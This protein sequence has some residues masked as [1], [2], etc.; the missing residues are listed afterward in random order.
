M[1]PLSP[2]LGRLARQERHYFAADGG[3][4]AVLLAA[5]SGMDARLRPTHSPRHADTLIVATPV[6]ERFL[7][8]L[9]ECYRSMPEPRSLVLV[10]GIVDG[11]ATAPVESHA[12]PAR[13]RHTAKSDATAASDAAMLLAHLGGAGRVADLA[14]DAELGARAVAVAGVALGSPLVHGAAPNVAPPAEVLVPV[15]F[16]GER[17]LATENAVVPIGP[18]QTAITAGPLALLL[19]T[20]GEQ[21]ARAD[22]DAGY[23]CRGLAE[24]FASTPWAECLAI[25]GAL[26]PLAPIAGRVAWARAV[27][28]L[29][30]TTTSAEEER[31]REHALS[32]ERAAGALAWLVRFADV[33]AYGWLAAAARRLLLETSALVPPPH[34]VV[35]GDGN[36]PRCA[37]GSVTDAERPASL[38]RAMSRLARRIERDRLLALRTRGLGVLPAA[39]VREAGVVGANLAASERGAGDV[40]ARLHER[41]HAAARDLDRANALAAADDAAIAT[42]GIAGAAPPAAPDAPHPSGVATG[43]AE[44][45]RGPLRITVES[46]GGAQPARVEWT[47]PSAAALALLPELLRGQ[48]LADALAIVASLDLSMAEADG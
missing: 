3:S 8:P 11:T 33:V 16:P 25:A 30:G 9:A 21:V 13:I 24:R 36:R 15:G 14:G 5:L 32:L 40:A 26:D 34:M 6:S 1:T 41:A 10:C 37:R 39:R 42:S 28:R 46:D 17:E 47:R 19:V 48:E 31:A 45:P 29:D 35:P 20:D 23:A 7:A 38:A 12:S 44:G 18:V 27:E 22:V 43:E 4:G 2:W